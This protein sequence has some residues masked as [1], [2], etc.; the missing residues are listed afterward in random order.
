[1]SK[2]KACDFEDGMEKERDDGKRIKT[3]GIQERFEEA[4][5][6]GN[7]DLL[8]SLHKQGGVATDVVMMKTII[9]RNYQCMRWISVLLKNGHKIDDLNNFRL[10]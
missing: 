5:E 6:M 10:D 3:N 1:M 8:V 9:S 7:F 4:A 2:R